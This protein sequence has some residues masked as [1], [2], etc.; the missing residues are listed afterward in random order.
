[1]H[2]PRG[3]LPMQVVI[4]GDATTDANAG[5]EFQSKDGALR[6]T[7]KPDG[8]STKYDL[9]AIVPAAPGSAQTTIS[10]ASSISAAEVRDG[11][12]RGVFIEVPPHRLCTAISRKA[13]CVLTCFSCPRPLVFP[14]LPPNPCL[15]PVP[16]VGGTN[17]P[18]SLSWQ[19]PGG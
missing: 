12:P 19:Q 10:A 3:L 2:G 14:L 15:Q 5:I 11:M 13:A 8:T 1:M 17:H 9:L 16:A 7:I 18:V 4:K 6:W